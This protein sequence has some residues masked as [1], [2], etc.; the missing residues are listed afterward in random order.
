MALPTIADRRPIRP[1]AIGLIEISLSTA[2][3]LLTLV[4]P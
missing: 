3:L 4:N 2:T 1:L